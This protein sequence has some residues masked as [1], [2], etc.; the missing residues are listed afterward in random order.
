M[1]Y[2]KV[3]HMLAK[4]K[5]QKV[6]NKAKT[7][8]KDTGSSPVQIAILNERILELTNHLKKNRKDHDSRKG[9]L[10]LVADRRSHERYLEKR[11]VKNDSNKA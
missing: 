4:T 1:L 7:H 6:I 8:E 9:L 3:L 11:K 5:K 10:Q 2:A